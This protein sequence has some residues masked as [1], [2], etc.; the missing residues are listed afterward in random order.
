MGHFLDSLFCQREEVAHWP[1]PVDSLPSKIYHVAQIPSKCG[2]I[3]GG[4]IRIILPSKDE[5][6]F[7]NRHQF[8]YLELVL[9]NVLCDPDLFIYYVYANGPGR[10]YDSR[11]GF[12]FTEFVTNEFEVLCEST[13]WDAF[14][15]RSLQI[16]PGAVLLGDQGYTCNNWL[17]APYSDNQTAFKRRFNNAHRKTRN[18][19]KLILC[20]CMIHNMCIK[21][22]DEGENLPEIPSTALFFQVR[23]DTKDEVQTS[24]RRDQILQL[25]S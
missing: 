16:F 25:F 23:D 1:D 18:A 12:N 3:G 22:G 5:D 9:I 14:K 6:A 13:L 17:I 20:A 24:A 15:V 21:V 8:N 10:W 7:F 19:A 4:H 11:V 2:C